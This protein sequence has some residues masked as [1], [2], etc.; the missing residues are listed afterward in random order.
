MKEVRFSSRTEQKDLEMKAE[1]VTTLLVRG[2]RV[3]I[4][5]QFHGNDKVEEVGIELLERAMSLLPADSVKV[6]NGPRVEKMRAWVM[7]R[8]IQE[9][10]T[11]KKKASTTRHENVDEDIN[12]E[13]AKGVAA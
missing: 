6:E 11:V 10:K 9:Q 5:V 4:A 8:P 1:V 13:V 12:T 7:I 2:H 3:K